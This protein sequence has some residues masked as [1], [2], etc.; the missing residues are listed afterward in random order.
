MKILRNS[1]KKKKGSKGEALA[2]DFL[3]ENGYTILEKNFR[4]RRGEID[5]I[6]ESE[7]RLSFVEVKNWDFLSLEDMAFAVTARKQKNIIETAKFFLSKNLGHINKI[8]QFDIVFITDN[9]NKIIHIKNA[10]CE[11]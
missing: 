6:A 3:K 10:F 7:G 5:I 11:G 1:Q 8:M 9:H 2:I 4:S